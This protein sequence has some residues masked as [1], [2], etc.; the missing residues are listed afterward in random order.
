MKPYI[1]PRTEKVIFCGNTDTLNFSNLTDATN[2]GNP[3]APA[4]RSTD[5]IPG[6]KRLER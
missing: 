5:I 2:A 1:I 4:R 6:N 3:G